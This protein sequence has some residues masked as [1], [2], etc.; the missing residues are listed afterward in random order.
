ME[1]A[2]EAPAPQFS[3]SPVKGRV[4]VGGGALCVG[5]GVSLLTSPRRLPSSR[6]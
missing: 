1:W 4:G 5:Y 6:A 2:A 3:P